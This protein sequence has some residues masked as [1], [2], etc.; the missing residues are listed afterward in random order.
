MGEG[1]TRQEK[2]NYTRVCPKCNSYAQ[3]LEEYTHLLAF[4]Y[5][6]ICKLTFIGVYK[7]P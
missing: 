4:Y 2:N 5:C 7:E 3:F 6:K 1:I